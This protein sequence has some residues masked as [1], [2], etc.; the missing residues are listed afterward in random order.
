MPSLIQRSNGYFYLVTHVNGKRVWQSTGAKTKTD[1]LK[2]IADRKRKSKKSNILTLGQF[3]TQF[4]SYAR[5]N[6]APS[7]ITLYDGAISNF[8]KHLGD[9]I[10]SEYTPQMIEQFKVMHLIKM[11]PTKVN[12]DFRS[13]KSVFSAA[14]RWGLILENPFCRCKQVRIPQTRPIFLTPDD[15]QKLL[16]VINYDWFRDIVRFAVSTMMRVGEIVNLRWSSIDLERKLILVENTEEYKT[17]TRKGRVV[18]MNEW[19]Y[20]FLSNKERRNDRVFTFPDGKP[21]RVGYVSSKFTKYVRKA[22]IDQRIHFHSLRHTG[23]PLGWCSR[24]FLSSP[25]NTFLDIPRLLLL[26]YIHIWVQ[27]I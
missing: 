20:Y 3:R 18:P 27:K 23:E 21:L 1:A 5:A 24:M 25:Y 2:F 9:L 7:T 26:R 19:V 10:L 16:S 4:L 22:P 8:I 15:F 13:L 6:L 11:S 12:I 14:M 17:K